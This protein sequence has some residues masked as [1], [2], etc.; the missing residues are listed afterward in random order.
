LHIAASLGRLK[1][2]KSL[3][4]FGAD[5]NIKDELGMTAIDRA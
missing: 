1:L 3:L 4:E 2:T 5:P